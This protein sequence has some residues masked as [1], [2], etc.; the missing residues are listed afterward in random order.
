MKRTVQVFRSFVEQ[1][2]WEVEYQISLTPEQ[3][4]RIAKAL[5]KRVYGD[6]CPDVRESQRHK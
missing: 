5:K 4:Q 1:E 3:R 2:K 6:H